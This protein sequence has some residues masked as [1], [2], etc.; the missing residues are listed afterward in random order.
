VL[1]H[2]SAAALH[3]L[4]RSDRPRVDVTAP[5][6]G[7]RAGIDVHRMTLAAADRTS[8]D[9]IPCTTVAR[10]LLDLA[11]VIDA[12][13][14]E[15]AMDRAEQLRVLDVTKIDDAIA[16]A[17][18]RRGVRGLRAA[19]AAYDPERLRTRSEL[20]RRFLQICERAGVPKPRVNYVLILDD[21]PVEI[22]FAW[23]DLRLAVETDGHA[24]H[25]TR[26]AFENDRR[27]DQ[28]LKRHG[29]DTL[30]FTWRQIA[31]DPAETQSTLAAVVN[32]QTPPS[33][34]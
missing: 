20:E 16:R 1:S 18:G 13:G 17:P 33:L 24:T 3:D 12:A 10:T 19:L 9:A 32:A 34:H 23:P 21:H 14:L 26:R 5:K 6:A 2:R 25:G 30:R 22:D 27:R 15:R 31:K 29:W 4:R 11:E 7:S 8:V 28:R